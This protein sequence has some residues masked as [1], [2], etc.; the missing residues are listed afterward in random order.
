MSLPMTNVIANGGDNLLAV[1][2]KQERKDSSDITFALELT[3]AVG[4]LV[5]ALPPPPRLSYSYNGATLRLSWS[6]GTLEQS[7]V[8]VG[9]DGSW[10]AVSGATSPYSV[11]TGTGKKFFR[12][13]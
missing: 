11:T 7:T 4:T 6:S 5:P 1:E 9:P 8:L 13:H 3:A 12:L 10:T 2:L